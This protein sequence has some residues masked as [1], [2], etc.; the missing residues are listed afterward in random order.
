[1]V[2]TER[3]PTQIVGQPI[4]MSSS[5]SEIRKP[6]PLAGEHSE[7]ILEEFGYGSEEIAALSEKGVI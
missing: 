5:K 2:S 6:P 4:M 3:G 7:E 1:M